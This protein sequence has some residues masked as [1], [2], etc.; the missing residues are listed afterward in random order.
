[1]HSADPEHQVNAYHLLFRTDRF[2]LSKV[3]PHFINPCCFGEDVSA[4]L[5]RELSLRGFTT[6][7]P[8]Q[9]DWGW[10]LPLKFQDHSYYLGIGGN[11]DDGT[12]QGEWRI[13]V[14]RRRSFRDFISG[15]G[16]IMRSDPILGA[17][18]EILRGEPDFR[19]I[20]CERDETLKATTD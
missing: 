1:M 14:Q 9:E 18:E 2:N 15:K 3:L 7:E 4:W 11:S 16:R 20:S 13:I 19:E 12:D 5:R 6:K 8:Y 10:E 17:V